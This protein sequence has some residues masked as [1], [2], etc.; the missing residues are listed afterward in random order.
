MDRSGDEEDIG[1]RRLGQASNGDFTVQGHGIGSHGTMM[2]IWLRSSL[3]WW[4]ESTRFKMHTMC[5]RAMAGK[6]WKGPGT[7]A[8]RP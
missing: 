6:A 2:G 4:L 1:N 8:D 7:E 5:D 3:D